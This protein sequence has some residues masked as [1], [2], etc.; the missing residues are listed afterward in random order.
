MLTVTQLVDSVVSLFK[1]EDVEGK[2]NIL[3][4]EA[5]D[6][7]ALSVQNQ[8][9]FSEITQLKKSV[10]G[11]VLTAATDREEYNQNRR[12]IWNLD[13]RGFPSVIFRVDPESIVEDVIQALA[14]GK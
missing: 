6:K 9:W 13:A 10:K 7:Y 1:S 2:R 3:E 5:L 8:I 4:N 14:F 11:T 12:E